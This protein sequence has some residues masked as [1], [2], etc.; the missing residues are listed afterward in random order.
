MAP[1]VLGE[2][3]KGVSAPSLCSWESVQLGHPEISGV[4]RVSCGILPLCPSVPVREGDPRLGDC[5]C[6]AQTW[7]CH[8]VSDDNPA[9]ILEDSGHTEQLSPWG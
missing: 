2:A 7:I 4:H 5:A 1:A 3:A 6:W 9:R 8:F